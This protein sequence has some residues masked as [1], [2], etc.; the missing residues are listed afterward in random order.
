MKPAHPNE[1][2]TAARVLRTASRLFY[3]HGV[4]AVGV[5]WIVA[6]SGV[7]KTS[8]YRHFHTK[9]DLIVAFLERED[10]DFWTEW[11]GITQRGGDDPLQQ[12]L[13]LLDWI[14][15][16]VSRNGYRGCPQ[17]N[18]AAEFS[19]P[20]HPARKIRARHKAEMFERLRTITSRIGT[21]RPD[22]AAYQLALLIDGAF[23]SDGRLSRAGA[24]R[25]LQSGARALIASGS[26][27]RMRSDPAA[28]KPSVRRS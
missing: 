25:I 21:R 7:A 8:I 13:A 28:G 11:D 3:E 12:L 15:Q 5:E 19:D 2:D 26:A 18:V 16:R 14:G 24:S 23:T 4:R 22:D 27:L 10:H 6:E 17:I 20:S 9:D 1:P